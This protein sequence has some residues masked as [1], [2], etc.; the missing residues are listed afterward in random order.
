MNILPPLRK[1]SQ[2]DSRRDYFAMLIMYRVVRMKESPFILPLFK[3]Y[4]TD[5]PNRG[6][7]KVLE[8]STVTTDSGLLSFQVKYA[9]LWNKIPPCIRYL[10]SYSKFKKSIKIH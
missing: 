7:R 10:S 5:K 3:P 4:Q 6:P 8:I 1:Q 9:E 2:T